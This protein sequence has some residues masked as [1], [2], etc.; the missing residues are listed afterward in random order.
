[1][2]CSHKQTR[3]HPVFWTEPCSPPL[4]TFWL[5]G[6]YSCFILRGCFWERKAENKRSARTSSFLLKKKEREKLKISYFMLFGPIETINICWKFPF[7]FSSAPHLS[8]LRA[9]T[10]SPGHTVS[11]GPVA[12]PVCSSHRSS[13]LPASAPTALGTRAAGTVYSFHLRPMLK[14]KWKRERDKVTDRPMPYTRQC[15]LN[16]LNTW[17]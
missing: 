14:M 10:V 8:G 13:P 2:P 1:M 12:P 4:S 16:V 6:R 3:T 9:V 7:T 5:Q 15:F 11:A 17:D